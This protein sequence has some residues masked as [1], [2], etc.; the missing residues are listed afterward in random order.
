MKKVAVVL[1]MLAMA[2]GVFAQVDVSVSAVTQLDFGMNINFGNDTVDTSYNEWLFGDGDAKIGVK[3]VAGPVSAGVRLQASGGNARLDY[4][5]AAVDLD[6][7]ELKVGFDWLPWVWWSSLDF[8]G[9]SNWGFGAAAVKDRFI[10]AKYGADALSI[11]AGLMAEGVDGQKLKDNAGFPGF[12]VGGD[13]ETDAFSIGAA[14]AGVARGKDW[15]LK[16]G[17]DIPD[18]VEKLPDFDDSW[19][20]KGTTVGESR[21]AWMGD[22]HAKVAFEP[23][24]VGLNVALY[25]DPAVSSSYVTPSEAGVLGGQKEDLVLEGMLDIGI[26]LDPCNICVSAGVVTNL[27]NKD[28]GGGGTGLQLGAD[29]IFQLG[30]GFNLIPGLIFTLPLTDGDNEKGSMIIGISCAYSF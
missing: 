8:F 29:A 9:N 30:G 23:V 1:L 6:P 5:F 20:S 4:Y 24:T 22:L 25:G 18:W 7:V 3:G 19:F 11:Y 14:F 12:Y 26:G 28:K 15:T 13:Y 21:F 17:A 16:S 10:Q 27:A 2:S